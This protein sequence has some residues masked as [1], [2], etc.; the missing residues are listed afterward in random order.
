MNDPFEFTDEGGNVC[1][2]DGAYYPCQVLSTDIA[3]P[4]PAP[5]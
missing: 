1:G 5:P 3:P 2:C 4:D